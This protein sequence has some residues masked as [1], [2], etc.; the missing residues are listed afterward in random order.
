MPLSSWQWVSALIQGATTVPNGIRKNGSR[1]CSRTCGARENLRG[2]RASE[3]STISQK[4][5][6]KGMV[7][8][9]TKKI[10]DQ[11]FPTLSF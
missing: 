7:Y 4:I 3:N 8:A 10:V 2:V 6:L 1:E 9:D 11:Y 5:V